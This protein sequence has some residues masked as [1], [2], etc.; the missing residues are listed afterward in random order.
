VL[1]CK[2]HDSGGNGSIASI[3]ECYQ[4]M[5]DEKAD[6]YDI[7][8]TNN[9]YGG[10][11]EACDFDQAT[12][13]GIAALDKARILFA[14]SAGNDSRDNDTAP[15]YPTNYFLPNIISTAAT[16]SS[17]GLPSF[18]NY[19]DRTVMIGAPGTGILST[20]PGNLYGRNS[21]TSMAAPHVAGLAG[22]LHAFNPNLNIYKIR[23]LI[24]A[25]GDPI[26]SLAG[27]T[28]SGNRL[29]ANGAMTCTNRPLFGM[30]RPLDTV[31]KVTQKVA[32]LN[33]DCA[34]GAGGLTVTVKPGGV[35]LTLKDGGANG[36]LRA[37][38]GIYSA[39]WTPPSK[40]TFTLNF[41]NGKAYTVVV[42]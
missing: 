20:L 30:L 11:P 21:G 25:G 26:A 38:D 28:V 8:A 5:V 27:K 37:N 29:N 10:C 23:N 2:S 33:I 36:D 4:Y 18:S 35:V 41:S 32:A 13:D 9:S 31:A 14:V 6:G 42:A 40:G 7:I 17:D 1:P 34:N 3:I 16:T 15:K 24:L 19:G 12:L 39:R 22:L